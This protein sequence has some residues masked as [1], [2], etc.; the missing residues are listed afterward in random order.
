[1]QTSLHIWALVRALQTEGCGG[2]ISSTA[3][4]RKERAA[5]IFIKRDKKRWALGFRYHPAGAG[6][7]LVPASKI[8]PDTREKPRPLFGFDNGTIV[9]A[10]QL[11]FDRIFSLVVDRS[12]VVSHLVFEALGPNGNLWHLDD[13][14]ARLSSLRKS[15][16]TPGETYE[17][18]PLPGRLDPREITIESLRANMPTE[19]CSVRLFLER[20]L[21]GFNRTLARE[22]AYRADCAD[23]TTESCDSEAAQRL[24]AAI[25]EIT[26]RFAQPVG[27]FLY[28]FGRAVEV[29][30]FRLSSVDETPERFKTLSLATLAMCDLKRSD[31]TATCG[32]WTTPGQG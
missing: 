8:R 11:G 3:F 6:V 23:V 12:G 18:P 20:N 22:A 5:Y 19:E 32:I 27:G 26:E 28:D 17:P 9:A 1:M 4:Y 29:Y 21:L 2:D 7:F 13:S 24:V 31:P 16:F 30:P 25:N 10:E 14:R 15:S